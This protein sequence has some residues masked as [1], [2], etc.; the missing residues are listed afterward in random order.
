MIGLLTA[1]LAVSSLMSCKNSSQEQPVKKVVIY[2]TIS[3]YEQ[4]TLF[5]DDYTS[6]YKYLE[7]NTHKIPLNKIM[8]S[9]IHSPSKNQDT[10]KYHVPIYTFHLEIPLK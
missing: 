10:L 4:D 9:L 3:N 7:A 8:N 6:N 5:M 2:G 1:I